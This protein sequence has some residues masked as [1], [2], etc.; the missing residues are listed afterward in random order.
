MAALWRAR[1]GSIRA[2][3]LML[4]LSSVLGFCTLWL[5]GHY[6]LNALEASTRQ[7]GVGKDIVADILPPPLYLIEAHLLAYQMLDTSPAQRASVAHALAALKQHYQERNAL[8]LAQR[9]ELESD[10]A[11][12]LLG[13]QRKYA[14]A[15]WALVESEFLP[16]VLAGRDVEARHVFTQLNILYATHRAGVDETVKVATQ[17]ANSRLDDLHQTKQRTHLFLTLVVS[18]CCVLAVSLFVLVARRIA[19]MLGAEPV[20]LHQEIVKLTQL[21]TTQPIP[22]KDHGSV[23]HA[24]LAAQESLQLHMAETERANGNL[25][26]TLQQLNHMVGT[27]LLTGLWSRRRMEEALANE[28]ERHQRYGQPL[29]LLFLDIDFFKQV[30]DQFGHPMG[31]QV[32]ATVALQMQLEQRATDTM[33][34]WG[35]EEFVVVCPNTTLDTAIGLAQRMRERVGTYGFPNVGHVT[36][37]IGVAQYKTPESWRDWLKRADEALLVAK[38]H[39]RNRV[40][41]AA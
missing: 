33:A 13:A 32:L 4:V 40:S 11:E 22:P 25:Q 36:L 8:W 16:L 3:L 20:Q 12:S 6:A 34:R 18:L 41:S 17:W 9:A 35:G 38:G 10:V 21:D 37:S 31:D 1:L 14:D 30:N 5:Q 29:S 26:S 19:N 15:Y 24:L 7:M 28:V 23:L 2:Q 27:D 39:G